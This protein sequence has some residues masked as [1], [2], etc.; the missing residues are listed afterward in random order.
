MLQIVHEQHGPR[1]VHGPGDPVDRQFVTGRGAKFDGVSWRPGPLGAPVLDDAVSWIECTFYDIRPGGDHLIVLGEVQEMAVERSTLP[2][3]FFQ[4]GYGR[5]TPGSLAA[6]PTPDLIQAAH[7]AEAI[8]CDVEA[9]SAEYG[10]NCS[11]LAKIGED[12]VHV[13]AANHGPVPNPF[14][15]GHRMPLV[16]PVTTATRCS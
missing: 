2:L 12:G 15:L 3:L 7:L 11:V 1:R 5:F 6:A 13:L 10:V 14:P 16:A 4:G 8:R 9:L